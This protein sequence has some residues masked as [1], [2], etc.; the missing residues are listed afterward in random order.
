M[1]LILSWIWIV[2]LLLGLTSRFQVNISVTLVVDIKSSR[3]AA[4]DPLSQWGGNI[5]SREAI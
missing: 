5:S 1:L 4:E 3:C 2:V